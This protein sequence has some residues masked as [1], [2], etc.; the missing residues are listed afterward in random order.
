MNTVAIV[1]LILSIANV[2][3]VTKADFFLN[4]GFGDIFNRR[5]HST[6][7]SNSDPYER[8]P[9]V[10][11]GLGMS[12]TSFNGD[13]DIIFE[14]RTFHRSPP[15]ERRDP[16]TQKPR[17]KN[18][19]PKRKGTWDENERRYIRRDEE[20]K[21]IPSYVR[22]TSESPTPLSSRR[23]QRKFNIFQRVDEYNRYEKDEEYGVPPINHKKS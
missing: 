11:F 1:S 3:F 10:S 8:D 22:T 2:I 15:F 16:I 21:E 23:P 9:Q 17:R 13:R 4:D 12:P 5:G 19:D 14:S 6:F 20:G 7:G 18:H